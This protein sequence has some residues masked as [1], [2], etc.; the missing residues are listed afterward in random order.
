MST[1][2]KTIVDI[3]LLGYSSI[4][5]AVE[6]TLATKHVIELNDQIQAF[7]NQG[8]AAAALA[9]TDAVLSTT[10]DGAILGFDEA[11][12]AYKFATA[13]HDAAKEWNYGKIDALAKRYFRVGIATGP[14]EVREQN[15]T[16]EF[17]GLVIARA[18]RLEAKAEPGSILVDEETYVKLPNPVRKAFSGPKRVRGKRDEVFDAYNSTYDVPDPKVLASLLPRTDLLGGVR[19]THSEIE[20]RREVLRL[21]H[22]LRPHQYEELVF[23]LMIP[24]DRRPP[25]TVPIAERRGMILEWASEEADGVR[26]LF[27]SLKLLTDQNSLL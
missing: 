1:I 17:A 9:R 13:L 23:L 16:R 27:E 24:I 26:N 10:G 7:V 19:G 2:T 5:R 8:L 25:R 21:L 11:A 6:E 18:V 14:I 3:D 20:A 22:S 12:Q 15:G 4:A